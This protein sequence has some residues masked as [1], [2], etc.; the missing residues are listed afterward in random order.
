MRLDPKTVVIFM[1]GDKDLLIHSR[2][3]EKLF[4]ICPC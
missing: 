4:N 2:N 1:S 3:S